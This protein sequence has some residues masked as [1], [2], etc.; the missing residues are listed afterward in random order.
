MQYLIM[1]EMS[2]FKPNDDFLMLTFPV[3]G[4][5][6]FLCDPQSP[7]IPPNLLNR[8][9]YSVHY[10]SALF[11]VVSIVSPPLDFCQADSR[12]SPFLWNLGWELPFH[13]ILW[14]RK[15]INDTRSILIWMLYPRCGIVFGIY[16]KGPGKV[17]CLF[18]FN[19]SYCGTVLETNPNDTQ[20]FKH[21]LQM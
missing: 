17:L 9:A 5:C 10:A 7:W 20:A 6:D 1:M 4:C 19:I 3:S 13:G 16:S 12:L 21:H 14:S 15:L 18:C 11:A 2:L 8:R